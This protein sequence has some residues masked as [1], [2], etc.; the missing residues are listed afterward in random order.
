[1]KPLSENTKQS[2]L[3]TI[4][5]F[6]IVYF[7]PTDKDLL[8]QL[9][10]FQNSDTLRTHFL[11]KVEPTIKHRSIYKLTIYPKNYLYETLKREIK[12]GLI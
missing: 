3:M 9:H 6:S 11:Y 2:S 10:H 1:M 8:L 5:D 7:L 4:E 12:E